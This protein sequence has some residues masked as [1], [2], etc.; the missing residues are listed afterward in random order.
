MQTTATN[1]P[2]DSAHALALVLDTDERADLAR[3]LWEVAHSLAEAA[4]VDRPRD[5][6]SARS[7]VADA[8]RA[9]DL[10]SALGW[11]DN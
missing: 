7:L 11:L 2:L 1:L 9:A 5:A 10:A 4:D 8:D 3:K 6:E